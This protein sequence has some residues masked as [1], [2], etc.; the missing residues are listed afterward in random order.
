MRL[1]MKVLNNA[2]IQSISGGEVHMHIP[3]DPN[4]KFDFST[5]F[6]AGVDFVG[7]VA[8]FVIGVPAAI[9]ILPV[10][11]VY[12]LGKSSYEYFAAK[13]TSAKG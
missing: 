11:G 5:G 3:V 7:G 1:Y 4:A 12:T 9:V 2:D 6:S 10:R 13:N 8:G